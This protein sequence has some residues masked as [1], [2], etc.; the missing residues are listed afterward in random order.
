MLNV[1]RF[2]LQPI[3]ITIVHTDGQCLLVSVVSEINT[4]VQNTK[5]LTS[6]PENEFFRIYL[7]Y[8]G[9]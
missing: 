2:S 1:V 7:G 6:V 8:L 9:Y 5:C 4:Y 3:V